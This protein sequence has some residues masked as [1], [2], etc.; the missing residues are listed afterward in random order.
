MSD[1][2]VGAKI[3]KLTSSCFCFLFNFLPIIDC[4]LHQTL[5]TDQGFSKSR[6]LLRLE[7][8][9]GAVFASVD[10]SF[11][12][13][14]DLSF[15]QSRALVN[16]KAQ[17]PATLDASWDSAIRPTE[18]M[19]SGRLSPKSLRQSR[20]QRCRICTCIMHAS[21]HNDH[22]ENTW[23]PFNTYQIVSGAAICMLLYTISAFL[24]VLLVALVERF[25]GNPCLRLL[26]RVWKVSV[27]LW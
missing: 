12:A 2:D 6:R 4:C 13:S 8:W 5:M 11:A 9:F 14:V 23:Q 24:M 22:L 19:R 17:P 15:A 20:A 27:D 1:Q 26:H 7:I 21:K 18:T 3:Q 16:A 10:L 25:G